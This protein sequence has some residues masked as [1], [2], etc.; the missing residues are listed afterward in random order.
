MLLA[1]YAALESTRS[2]GV[3]WYIIPSSAGTRLSSISCGEPSSHNRYVAF[4]S[5]STQPLLSIAERRPQ[6]SSQ[7]RNTGGSTASPTNSVPTFSHILRTSSNCAVVHFILRAQA[8]TGV[9]DQR[10][11]T[12]KRTNSTR[13]DSTHPT[14][15]TRE[16]NLLPPNPSNALPTAST[17]I[18]GHP[19]PILRQLNGRPANLVNTS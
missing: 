14:P 11:P 7:K 3:P 16:S 15:I 5:T 2:R 18:R 6:P 1:H 17:S 9:Q 13:L 19:N 10:S 8:P 4:T 12:S